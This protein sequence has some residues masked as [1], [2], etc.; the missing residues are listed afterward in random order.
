MTYLQDGRD[1]SLMEVPEL[2]HLILYAEH[3]I[4]P[5]HVAEW[6]GCLLFAEES[7][8]VYPEQQELANDLVEA[9]R[10][11][12][13]LFP[14]VRL[15]SVVLLQTK[16]DLMV[17]D[18][19]IHG[20]HAYGDSLLGPDWPGF[21]FEA[22]LVEAYALDDPYLAWVAV[23]KLKPVRNWEYA[24]QGFNATDLQEAAYYLAD[25]AQYYPELKGKLNKLAQVAYG[26]RVRPEEVKDAVQV[27]LLC[28]EIEAAPLI[29]TPFVRNHLLNSTAVVLEGNGAKFAKKDQSLDAAVSYR[30]PSLAAVSLADL[31]KLR[32]NED[33]YYEVRECLQSLAFGVAAPN[34]PVSFG[35]YEHEVREQA[36]DIVR[37]VCEKLNTKLKREKALSLVGGYG[38]GSLISL[39]INGLAMLTHGAAE[40]AVRSTGNTANNL[41]KNLGQ[42]LLGRDRYD[43]STACSILVSLLKDR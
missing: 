7:D 36:E 31:I 40:V 35:A 9:V 26:N 20:L 11:I 17:R 33:I 1:V 43:L 39:G 15:G 21:T 28:R 19:Y 41:G 10:A 25:Q 8:A 13:P 34:L 2:K 5:D 38:I 42:R 37:P 3:F 23:N 22:D 30:V 24:A 18:E 6:A 14:L 32:L 27:N 29:S 4:L 12:E 16:N